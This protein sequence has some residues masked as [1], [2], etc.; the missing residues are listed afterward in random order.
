LRERGKVFG[1]REG[2]S[3]SPGPPP[4]HSSPPL[5]LCVPVVEAVVS[6]ARRLYLRAARKGL[7][8][9]LRL[10]YLEK[11]DL[12][13]LL[14]TRPG[15]VIATNRRAAEGGRW[16]GE[17]TARLDLLEKTLGLGVDC[18]DVEL[19]AD[20]V[21]RREVWERRGDTRIILSWH[22]FS[23]TPEEAQLQETMAEMLGQ[24]ADIIKLVT[25]ARHPEDNLRVLSL[26]PQARARGKEVI[27]FCMGP[28]GKWSR[29][30]APLLGSFLTY[31]P[32]S[33]RGSSAPGQ[34]TVN[35]LRRL[36]RTLK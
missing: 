11:P 16:Q 21:W 34:L 3:F 24:P 5:R 22:D 26:I 1:E 33:R 12:T 17:E 10:D 30:A 27:A 14:R 6:R 9:E 2:E 29:I 23:G 28:A 25:L 15:P 32:F 20:P 35:E 18:L 4:K 36:W 13:R 31:A 7:W 8:T 19:A